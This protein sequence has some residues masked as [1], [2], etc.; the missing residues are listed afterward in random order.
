M[1]EVALY[2]RKNMEIDSDKQNQVRENN[3]SNMGENV[4][5]AFSTSQIYLPFRKPDGTEMI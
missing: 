5:N 1:T 2:Q 3:E 4:K